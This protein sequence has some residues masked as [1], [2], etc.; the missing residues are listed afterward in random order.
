MST[1]NGSFDIGMGV[2][3]I[4]S[5]YWAYLEL[6]IDDFLIRELYKSKC[7][8]RSFPYDVEGR[9]MGMLP[10]SSVARRRLFF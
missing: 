5:K 3:W 6:R 10:L 7:E 9:I 8:K 4:F 1:N 2:A